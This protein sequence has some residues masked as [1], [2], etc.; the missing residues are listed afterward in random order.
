LVSE[1]PRPLNPL[2]NLFLTNFYDFVPHQLVSFPT[3]DVNGCS[4][5][6]DHFLCDTPDIVNN[7]DVIPGI[8]DHYALL[9]SPNISIPNSNCIKNKVYNYERA[10]WSRLN[11]LLLQCL[12]DYFDQ[13]NIDDACSE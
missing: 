6:L 11:E 12:P 3:R 7:V 10:N 9:T 8:S 4:S 2:A 5:T 13:N 1:V